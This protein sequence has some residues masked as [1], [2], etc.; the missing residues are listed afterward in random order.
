MQTKAPHVLP[1]VRLAALALAALALGVLA[2]RPGSAQSS[3]KGGPDHGSP[4]DQTEELIAAFAKGSAPDA[5]EELLQRNPFFN[6][7]DIGK[8]EAD[9][10]QLAGNVRLYL[11]HERIVVEEVTARLQ[12]LTYVLHFERQPILLEIRFYKP[13]GKTWVVLGY[14]FNVDERRVVEV[15]R[16]ARQRAPS[17]P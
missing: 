14:D 4:Q 9:V 17:R 7:L 10:R 8:G 3:G 2:P 6:E 12:A 13:G 15:V 1:A 5:M 11:D 16:G